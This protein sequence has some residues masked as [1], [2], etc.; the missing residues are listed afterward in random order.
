MTA[1][2]DYYL[3]DEGKSHPYCITLDSR[4][5][6]LREISNYKVHRVQLKNFAKKNVSVEIQWIFSTIS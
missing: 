4:R 6:K 5:E 2:N 3:E 1:K